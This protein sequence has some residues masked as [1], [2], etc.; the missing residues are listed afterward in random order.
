MQD[1]SNSIHIKFHQT[2]EDV[3]I[4]VTTLLDWIRTGR[5]GPEDMV[6]GEIMTAGEWRRLEDMRVF[7]SSVRPPEQG[8]LNDYIFPEVVPMFVGEPMDQPDDYQ[9]LRAVSLVLKT[10]SFVVGVYGIIIATY[11]I[12]SVAASVHWILEL[13]PAAEMFVLAV[14]TWA[15]AEV[16]PVLIDI[17][18]SL[19]S[20]TSLKKPEDR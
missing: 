16:I 19:R 10:L 7:Y 9:I 6:C 8:P 1:G 2:D 12:G 14:L 20:G 18:R 17:D 15:L 3:L 5:L 4:D 11:I 13:V